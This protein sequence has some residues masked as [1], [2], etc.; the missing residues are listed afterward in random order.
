MCVTHAAEVNRELLAF[1]DSRLRRP[2]TADRSTLPT[3]ESDARS[4]RIVLEPA[5]QDL[6]DATAKPPFLYELESR[7][8]VRS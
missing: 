6:A 1:S 2:P 7:P 4:P 3:G 8:P 5:A